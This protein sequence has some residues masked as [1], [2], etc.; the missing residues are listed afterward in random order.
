M[1]KILE[2]KFQLLIGKCEQ[3]GLKH[4]KVVKACME[5]SNFTRSFQNINN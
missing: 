4:L 1:Q 2:P 5:Y 3:V